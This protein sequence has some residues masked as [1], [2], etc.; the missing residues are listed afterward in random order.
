VMQR[1]IISIITA[2]FSVT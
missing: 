1:W 2:V